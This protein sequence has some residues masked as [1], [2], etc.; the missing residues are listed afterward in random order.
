[1]ESDDM[2]LDIKK[3]FH[4]H[5]GRESHLQNEHQNFFKSFLLAERYLIMPSSSPCTFLNLKIQ[6]ILS[7][8]TAFLIMTHSVTVKIN[9]QSLSYL[10]TKHSDLRL[11]CLI[12][13]FPIFIV[14]LR[15]TE[16]NI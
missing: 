11:Q 4:I 13:T 14:L 7:V 5:S 15:E 10:T 12:I 6:A 8:F 9:F 2:L 3:V 1:M 16:Q